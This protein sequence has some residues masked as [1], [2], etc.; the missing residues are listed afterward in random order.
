MMMM[1][2]MIMMIFSYFP[3]VLWAVCGHHSWDASNLDGERGF[4]GWP[5]TRSTLSVTSTTSMTYRK[6]ASRG[7]N[8]RSEGEMHV[9]AL[10]T[11]PSRWV[12]GRESKSAFCVAFGIGSV[13][14]TWKKSRSLADWQNRCRFSAY[15][16]VKK[17]CR[18]TNDWC[19]VF[20]SKQNILCWTTTTTKKDA[21]NIL[22]MHGSH[23]LIVVVVFRC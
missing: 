16:R 18:E 2:M 23:E 17:K 10:D 19:V 9:P 6:W 1:M 15:G 12:S 20:E 21:I 22:C 8:N 4:G 5:S 14:T 3:G 11:L 7:K 13:N